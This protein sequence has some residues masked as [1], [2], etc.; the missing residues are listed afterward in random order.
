MRKALLAAAVASAFASPVAVTS[1]QAQAKSPHTFTGNVAVVSDYRFRGISQTYNLPAL[2]G[3]FDYSHSSGLYFGNWNSSVSG[4]V[5]PNGSG[6]EMDFYGGWKTEFSNG[7]GL[8]IGAIYYFYP[9]ARY[10][11]F[12]TV[13]GNTSI[14]K[15]GSEYNNTEIYIG[16]SYKWFSLKYYHATSDYFGINSTALNG[17]FAGINSNG[18]G[19]GNTTGPA[20]GGSR[21]T[22]YLDLN[23]NFEIF[24]KATLG[25]H[26]G[27]LRVKN[28]SGLNYTDY[29][30]SLAYDFGWATLGVAYVATNASSQ[31]YR[32]APPET[33]RAA[34]GSTKDGSKDAFV[35]TISKTF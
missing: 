27:Q 9:G 15:T 16:A 33:F 34:S 25:L 24:P 32:F 17:T 14:V 22:G 1:V 18:T 11:I 5:F 20:S 26:V 10:N 6:V 13:G 7:I 28:Y 31:Y 4:N 8:D 35:F 29:K 2:Q 23:A 3:G 19:T 12:P 21:G 30:V